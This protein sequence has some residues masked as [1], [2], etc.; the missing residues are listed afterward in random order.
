MDWR[1]HFLHRDDEMSHLQ[2]AWTRALSG[3]PQLVVLLGEI[4]LGKTRLALEFYRWLSRERD[5]AS[6]AHPE[7]YWPDAFAET[8]ASL[9]VNPCFD[10]TDTSARPRIPW[11]WWGLRWW[12]PEERNQTGDR[13]ALVQYKHALEPHVAPI[14]AARQLQAL[15]KDASWKAAGIGLN[16]VPVLNWLFLLRDTRSLFGDRREEHRLEAEK[17]ESVGQSASRQRQDLETLVLDSF[18]AILDPTKKDAAT[19]PVVLFL[20]DAQWA[21]ETT[22][23]F[24]WRLLARAQEYRWPLLVLATHYEKEWEEHLPS[25]VGTSPP[26]Q[27]VDI[28]RLIGKRDQWEGLRRLPKIPEL[29]PIV[30]DALPG[31]TGDQVKLILSRADGNPLLLEDILRELLDLPSLFENRDAAAALTQHGEDFVRD[32]SFAVHTRYFRRFRALE[33][34]VRQVLG[35]SS[36]QGDRFL[37]NVTKEAARQCAPDLDDDAIAAAL[38]KAERPW[39]QRHRIDSRYNLAEFR[40]RAYRDVAR[41]YLSLSP[42]EEQLVQN[43]LAEILSQWVTSGEIDSLPEEERLDA[44]LM[45][46]RELR[47]S[48]DDGKMPWGPWWMAMMELAGLYA[49]QY[50]WSQAR[51]VLVDCVDVS[52][53]HLDFSTV[54]L[55][56]VV[57]IAGHL[58]DLE[59]ASSSE[60][61]HDGCLQAARSEGAEG[62]S[63]AQYRLY[64]CLR[65]LARAR[66]ALGRPSEAH[67]LRQEAAVVGQDLKVVFGED[68]AQLQGL[69]QERLEQVQSCGRVTAGSDR[70]EQLCQ[71]LELGIEATIWPEI[72][73]RI[74][75]KDFEGAVAVVQELGSDPAMEILVAMIWEYAGHRNNAALAYR[76]ALANCDGEPNEEEEYRN[77]IKARLGLAGVVDDPNEQ[78]DLYCAT[79]G[80]GSTLIDRFGGSPANLRLHAASC[81]KLGALVYSNKMFKQSHRLFKEATELL[82][83]LMVTYDGGSSDD[84]RFV[85][86]YGMMYGASACRLGDA[87]AAL[88]CLDTAFEQLRTSA[89]PPQAGVALIANMK[90]AIETHGCPLPDHLDLVL[91]GTEK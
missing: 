59:A 9:D 90:S 87:E 79:I 49:G 26:Q 78:R 12:R 36:V 6:S 7:G 77:A 27:F 28:P 47:P 65:G 84:A 61:W 13:C 11:L 4:G 53:G 3:D 43:S 80:F 50:L 25:S 31:L 30:R 32:E 2:A 42:G 34:D 76:R 38:A 72:E 86:Y 63:R 60:R 75:E 69:L 74:Q 58:E 23:R 46:K 20:D 88:R 66:E 51:T 24:V 67:A 39:I 81:A 56:A 48:A 70:E 91:D 62:D 37:E 68:L 73:R 8:D 40:Q 22:L 18:E 33:E 71:T 52:C 5:P 15:R 64:A 45:A 44:L 83:R 41:K 82:Q 1:R 21:D 55:D 10:G 19:V 29:D 14:A 89:N 35:W 54:P 16:S 17:I 85:V 57:E